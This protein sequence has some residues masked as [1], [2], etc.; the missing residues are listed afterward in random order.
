M[1]LCSF[2]PL[3]LCSPVVMGGEEC[4]W[5]SNVPGAFISGAE[6]LA[7][8][9]ITC[10]CLSRIAQVWK[11]VFKYIFNNPTHCPVFPISEVL[12]AAI[13]LN[14]GLA[15]LKLIVRLAEARP[16]VERF[17]FYK[18]RS[19]RTANI[20]AWGSGSRGQGSMESAPGQPVGLAPEFHTVSLA[21]AK[22]GNSVSKAP[23]P[24]IP[25]L[26]HHPSG[27]VCVCSCCYR[28]PL[29]GAKGD[30]FALT[31]TCFPR[32]PGQNSG[33]LW[34]GSR[35]HDKFGVL[36]SAGQW[37]YKDSRTCRPIS[38]VASEHMRTACYFPSLL[39]ISTCCTVATQPNPCDLPG[40]CCPSQGLC[41]V[42]ATRGIFAIWHCCAMDAPLDP[43]DFQSLSWPKCCIHTCK[44]N[45][46][47][48]LQ[49]LNAGLIN[50]LQISHGRTNKLCKYLNIWIKV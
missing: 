46:K 21:P 14:R 20:T 36:S 13:K 35:H 43:R 5:H 25:I 45:L 17:L 44:I 4:V 10:W 39:P 31:A 37:Y 41:I 34:W 40:W 16:K 50:F 1:W 22:W 29:G 2:L 8:E 38:G 7:P 24:N 26:L 33:E 32:E 9:V 18:T 48:V 49:T 23:L 6:R 3:L 19:P 12:L 30:L 27:G 28:I 11:I 15:L 47:K 42:H